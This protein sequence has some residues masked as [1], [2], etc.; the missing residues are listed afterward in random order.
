[1]YAKAQQEGEGAMPTNGL[2]K[3]LF[4][5]KTEFLDHRDEVREMFKEIKDGQKEQSEKLNAIATDVAVMKSVKNVEDAKDTKVDDRKF[6]W[7]MVAVAGAVGAGFQL[8][9]AWIQTLSH[10]GIK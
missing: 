10:T 3:D 7:W 5:R 9:V 4:V 8:F 1:M 2:D 6:S